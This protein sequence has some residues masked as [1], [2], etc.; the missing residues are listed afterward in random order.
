MNA[1]RLRAPFGDGALLA[2]P[3]LGAVG[4]HLAENL[5]RLSRWDHDFQ[6]RHVRWLRP[7]ARRR[8][9]EKAR[10]Y[11]GRS[12][13]DVPTVPDASA[14]L[15]IAGHQPELFHP[16][17]WVKN[18]ATAAIAQARGGVG[19]NLIVDNDLAKFP[20]IRVPRLH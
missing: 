5:D 13:L 10:D 16:G 11:L 20:A 19:L 12:G 2:D 7:L 18:F 17:V 8:A 3:P 9:L 1:H 14:P 4:A 6:G 15:V